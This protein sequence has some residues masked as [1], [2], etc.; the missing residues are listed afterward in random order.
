MAT[1]QIE[2]V[3]RGK[4]DFGN[5]VP[6]E[7]MPAIDTGLPIVVLG[8][9]HVGCFELF[10]RQ[11]IHNVADLMGKSVG[12]KAAPA[13]L[14]TLMAAQVGL[15]PARYIRWVTERYCEGVAPCGRPKLRISYE[16]R[17]PQYP[18]RFHDAHQ[19]SAFWRPGA[20][21]WADLRQAPPRQKPPPLVV[22]SHEIAYDL[23]RQFAR[24]SGSFGVTYRDADGVY[25]CSGADKRRLLDQLRGVRTAAVIPNAADIEYYRPRPTDPPSDG[26]TVVYFG[27]LSTVP[28]V[29]G[30][31]QFAR[32]IWPRIAAAHPG[33]R[34]KIIGGRPP[35]SLLAHLIT[36]HSP[37]A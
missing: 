20:N 2:A 37:R 22:D 4:I 21:A 36:P 6:F 28:N 12:L 23:A 18:V 8:G 31:I 13:A 30:M 26:R 7:H 25:L 14:L 24:A 10:A 33:A 27:L 5:F 19:P 16:F 35:P 34:W 1:A 32:N 17:A 3:G 9:V 15:D 11:D 29:D